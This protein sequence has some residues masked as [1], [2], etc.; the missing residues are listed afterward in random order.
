M[1]LL[2][3]RPYRAARIT[4]VDRFL[5]AT[6]LTLFPRR[7]VPNHLTIFRLFTVPFIAYLIVVNEFLYGTILFAVSAFTDALDG[8][9]ARTR[10]QITEW[11]T[12]FDP[13]ADKLLIGITAIILIPKYLSAPLAFAIIFIEMVLI[14]SAY[15]FRNREGAV[16]QANVW[17]KSKMLFQSFGIGFLFLHG[18]TGM[19]FALTI[20][21]PLLYIA[22]ILAV[23]SVVTYGI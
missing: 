13:L 9:M 18:L 11:G 19:A 14:G 16:I 12:L 8:A 10:G 15:Y 4:V 3:Q 2:R 1:A 6:L 20:A 7:V 5:A 22:I 17:G 21:A 23:V